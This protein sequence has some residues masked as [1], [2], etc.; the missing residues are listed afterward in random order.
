MGGSPCRGVHLRGK[1]CTAIRWTRTTLCQSTHSTRRWLLRWL[2]GKVVADFV[3]V[4]VGF[5]VFWPEEGCPKCGP[6]TGSASG[7]GH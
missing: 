7:S 6:G 3:Q 5:I 4:I 2:T 1:S